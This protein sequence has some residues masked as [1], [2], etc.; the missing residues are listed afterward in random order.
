M[1][2]L[3]S[4]RRL[5][6]A[7]WFPFL[8]ADRLKRT[9][10][11]SPEALPDETP[12]VFV[13]KQKGAM[14]IIACS[15]CA[16]RSGLTVGMGLADARAQLPHIGIFDIDRV[17]DAA[18]LEC[19][20]DGCD[21]YT[22]MVTLDGIDGLILDISG[23]AHLFGGEEGLRND[24]TGRL[25]K[26]GM[27]VQ[28]AL[29]ATP[30]AAHAQARYGRGH[31]GA[32]P[33]EALELASGDIVALRRAGL[34]RIG[35]LTARPTTPIATRFG[36]DATE[37][38]ARVAGGRDTRISPRRP[39]PAL[40]IEHNFA[41]P[42]THVEAVLST[43]ER[44]A[45][46]AAQTMQDARRGGRRFEARLFRADGVVR[47]LRI[48]TS[49][50][51]RDIPL[52]MRL[53]RERIETLH[54]P[55]DPGFGFDLVRFAVP[56]LEPLDSLQLPLVG[57]AVE[58]D[59]IARLVD[60]LST[61]LGKGRVRRFA[62]C[63][64]H[65]PEQ[66]MLAFPAIDPRPVAAWPPPDAGEP[67]RR[68]LHLFDPPQRIRVIAGLPEGPPHQFHWRRTLH[69]V[70]RA[71]GPERI[72]ALWWRRADNEGLGRDY[73]R[74]EDVHGRRFWLFRHGIPRRDCPNPGWYLHGLFA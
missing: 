62:H 3:A 19:M 12:L 33:V 42:I 25:R 45:F 1:T 65:I 61:R 7:I 55:I 29:A 5:Y 26:L 2:S 51:T 64:N 15:P 54:D 60:R 58:Q 38:L 23:C 66:A 11:Q 31:I 16:V 21:R 35:D 48:E 46:K 52:L 13:E 17:S 14:R 49:L 73:Y 47:S 63:D 57:G 27:H 24:L 59:E 39:E 44:L 56:L 37:R 70:A 9:M 22:P 28:T 32:L 72:A 8:A 50:P 30:D 43:L 36:E 40:V 34:N 4:A 69:E 53:F 10:R 20:A 71:E 18:W 67:P 68:P 6:L 41:E 74:V